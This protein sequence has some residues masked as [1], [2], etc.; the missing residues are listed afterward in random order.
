MWTW[1][2]GC[3]IKHFLGSL[4]VCYLPLYF[5]AALNPFV[6]GCCVTVELDLVSIPPPLQ[7]AR[8]EAQAVEGAR[9][10]VRGWASLPGSAYGVCFLFYWGSRGP[11]RG[12]PLVLTPLSF[13]GSHP[14]RHSGAWL[15]SLEP[16]TPWW[17]VSCLPVWAVVPQGEAPN[18]AVP[19]HI[20]LPSNLCPDAVDQLW[21]RSAPRISSV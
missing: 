8:C 20:T 10:T 3:S 1:G 21:L 14:N 19:A 16:L 4:Y 17:G 11:S 15:L 9:P 12:H 7:L 13:S 18:V 5:L 2:P 6:I